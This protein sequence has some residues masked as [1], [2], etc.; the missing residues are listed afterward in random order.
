MFDVYLFNMQTSDLCGLE[1]DLSKPLEYQTCRHPSH[2]AESYKEAN[3]KACGASDEIGFATSEKTDA[4]IEALGLPF[5]CSSACELK[6]SAEARNICFQEALSKT[7]PSNLN[8]TSVGDPGLQPIDG[9]IELII[10]A[11]RAGIN[12]KKYSD[13]LLSILTEQI[14]KADE[15]PSLLDR[16]IITLKAKVLTP[17]QG[18]FVRIAQLLSPSDAQTLR[19]QLAGS[20]DKMPSSNFHSLFGWSKCSYDH[21]K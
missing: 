19:T 16:I 15:K 14:V 8:K 3:T 2:G 5:L 18:F 1:N 4:E 21:R 11:Q 13:E 20:I 10:R 6:T 7:F 12:T 17:D 9:L